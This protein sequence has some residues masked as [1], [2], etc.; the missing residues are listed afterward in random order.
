MALVELSLKDL[1]LPLILVSN[2]DDPLPGARDHEG[3]HHALD[4]E[5]RGVLHDEPVLDRARLALVGVADDVLL[6]PRRV[7]DDL[8]LE[9]G[10]ESSPAHPAQAAGLESRQGPRD[11]TAGDQLPDGAVTASRTI[12]IGH[13]GSRGDAGL[14]VSRRSAGRRAL[15]MS[16]ERLGGQPGAD[17]VIDRGGRRAI[18]LPQA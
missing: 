10:A 5:M 11:V 9:T 3:H 4:D 16:V 6:P 2:V 7:L 17:H 12:R 14:D 18:T 13:E 8:P 1:P 15:D